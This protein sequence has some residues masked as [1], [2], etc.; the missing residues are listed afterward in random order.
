VSHAS[1]E[2][3]GSYRLVRPLGRSRH[4]DRWLALDQATQRSHVMHW[5]TL[6][7]VAARQRLQLDSLRTLARSLHDL[8]ILEIESVIP[9]TRGSAQGVWILTPYTGSVQGLVTLA[10][11]QVDKGGTMPVVEVERAMLHLLGAAEAGSAIGRV[12]GPLSADEVHVDRHG[13]LVIELYA[14]ATALEPEKVDAPRLEREEIRSIVDMGYRL[15]TNRDVVEPRLLV[16]R[17][18]RGLHE[19]WDRWFDAGLDPHGGFASAAEALGELPSARGL[20]TAAAAPVMVRAF[21]PDVSG[22]FAASGASTTGG[23]RHG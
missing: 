18:I 23:V 13:R 5:V 20:S 1:H 3:I 22:A 10:Q 15:L 16:S 21:T 6:D 2:Q 12:H 8:H 7:P 17:L 9:S 4:G 19:A 11:L 14:L